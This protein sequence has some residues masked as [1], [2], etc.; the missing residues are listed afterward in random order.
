MIL[1]KYN[2]PPWLRTNK[3]F[4]L[5]VL[6]ILGKELMTLEVFEVYLDLVVEEF[7]QLWA[8]IPGYYYTKDVG[9][10]AFTL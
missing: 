7:L 9:F 5:L 10:K 3:F 6:L 1:L 8:G 4:M 2:H